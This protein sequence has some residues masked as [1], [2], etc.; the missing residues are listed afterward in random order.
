MSYREEKEQI[1]KAVKEFPAEF[2]LRAFPGKK[3]RVCPGASYWSE[4]QPM[5]V[6]QV[7][8]DEKWL[9]FSKGTPYE[10]ANE[11]RLLVP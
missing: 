11:V 7:W 4:G 10:L 5:L 9:D 1:E 2:G 6:V 8:R 3:F